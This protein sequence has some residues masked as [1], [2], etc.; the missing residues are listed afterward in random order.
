MAYKTG[1]AV[2]QPQLKIIAGLGN[3]G[4][5]YQETRH[6]VG[7]LVL[8]EQVSR[9]G[10]S[11]RKPLFASSYRY[12]AKG[13]GTY[14]LYI[15]PLTYMNRSGDILPGLMKKHAVQA[16]QVLVVCDNMDLPP[17]SVRIKKGGGTAGHNGLKSL[18]ARIGSADFLRIYV[19]IGRPDDNSI[20][21]HVL[22]IPEDEE[23][24]KMGKGVHLASKAVEYLL[25]G[26][27][28]EQVMNRFNRKEP[29]DQLLD[30]P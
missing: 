19:G 3:P 7:F 13:R 12:A 27:S 18:V 11:W 8:E 17:G 10:L 4:R 15:K 21:S 14:P 5:Q 26:E 1:S 6:N 25:G 2:E 9:L 22:G 24:E 30:Q 29:F 16:S 28:V 20:V 23:A